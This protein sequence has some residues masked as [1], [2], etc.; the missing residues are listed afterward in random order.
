MPVALVVLLVALGGGVVWSQQKE[1]LLR[2]EGCLGCHEG[3]ETINKKMADAWGADTRCEVCHHGKPQ[4]ATK[5]EAHDGLIANPSD[6]RVIDR[7]C[8]RCHS[9][10]GDLAQVGA[11]EVDN[12][13]G[14]VLRSLMATAAGEIAGTRYLW[15]EQNT[16]SALYGVR[17]AADLD[18]QHPAGAVPRVRGLPAASASNADSLLRAC[19]R[20]HLWTEDK[21][22]PGI[23][24]PA[25]CAACHVLYDEDGLSR[26]GD[27]TI[28]KEERGHPAAHV[29]TTRIP[30]SQ[31]L[32]CHNDGGARIGL[33]YI[34]F[35][36][37]D[38]EL[39][40]DSPLPGQ[41]MAYGCAVVPVTPDIH[42]LR[43]MDCID[44]HDTL[45]VHGDGN[46]YSHQEHATGIRCEDCHGSASAAPD[47]RTEAGRLLKHVDVIEGVTY[48][49]ARLTLEM[50]RIPII[51]SDQGEADLSAIW[52][53]GHQRLECYACHST[54]APQC[55]VCHMVRDDA[56]P[57]PVDWVEG[58][59]EGAEPL[60]SAGSWTG[61]KLFQAWTQPVLGVNQRDRIAPFVPG[62]QA[63]LTRLDAGGETVRS[64]HTFTTAGGLYGF[65]LNPV[66]PHS[67]TTEAPTCSSCHS[68]RKA[69][70]LGSEG[71]ADLKRLGLSVTF[72]P[73]MFVDEEGNR[74]QDSSRDNVRPFTR[75]ELIGIYRTGGCEYCHE[76][77]LKDGRAPASQTDSITEADR[78]HKRMI[79]RAVA[80]VAPAETSKEE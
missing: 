12:H 4:A 5:L 74:V 59:G 64:N 1:P 77:P 42:Y 21:R 65:S 70:G 2:G 15:N 72:S 11:N 14:R 66:H 20:C 6:F 24:R 53:E 45:D 30:T 68:E 54:G 39:R 26:S 57:S 43:G 79:E 27:P 28:P 38:A 73:D 16:R 17:A 13:V 56:K 75:E 67:V 19:L 58:L 25:G 31:C 49:Q 36:V 9:D 8:G 41:R 55:Y 60:E 10:Y 46:L 7:T 3:I 22:T 33:S 47:F 80:P 76:R 69:L 51:Y 40:P 37:M 52:H 29:I 32:W 23:F 34:G 61:R 62:G 50:H 78:R 63:V 48:L 35:S 44:C 18:G 71:F